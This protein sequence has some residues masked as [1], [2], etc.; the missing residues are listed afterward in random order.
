MTEV[1][2]HIKGLLEQG[3]IEESVSP[4]AAPVVLRKVLKSADYGKPFVVETDASFDS[5]GA[6]LS[7]EYEGNLHPVAFGSRGLRR[8]ERNMSNY[9]SRKLELIVLK[10]AVTEQFKLYQ[11]G[12]KFVV[13]TDN[14][15]LVH[16]QKAKLGAVESRFNFEVKYRP[17]K[18]NA[19][20]D[21]LSRRPKIQEE[22]GEIL[23]EMWDEM[24]KDPP[25]RGVAVVKVRDHVQLKE[26]RGAKGM[27]SVG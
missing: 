4:Y 11:A 7:Q 14:N 17:G 19:N 23:T 25:E 22:E 20:A 6:V 8:S 10:W 27:S 12:G 9:S 26:M 24:P 13:L 15:P 21:G 1:K 2:A 18:E 3:V 16:L 5:L